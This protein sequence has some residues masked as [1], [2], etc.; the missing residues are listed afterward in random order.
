MRKVPMERISMNT[1]VK[2]AVKASGKDAQYDAEAKRLLGNKYILVYI[3]KNI[4]DEFRGM[5]PADVI[6]YIEG[7]P[8]IGTV[9]IEPGLTN[10]T[11][12]DFGQRVVGLNSE[13]SEINEGM[14]KFD[15]VFY[16][17]IPSKDGASSKNGTSSN[18]GT[19]FKNGASDK[20]PQI[21]VNAEAQKDA[22]KGYKILN[23]AVFYVSRLIS[24]Q[25]ERDFTNSNYDDLKRIFSIW[26]YMNAKENSTAHI[27]LSRDKI[28]GSHDGACRLDLI[29]IVQIGLSDELPE[30]SEPYELHR[31]LGALLSR[32]LTVDEKLNIIKNEYNI[33]IEESVR[34]DVDDM[35]NL[36][37]GIREEGMAIGR[38][39]GR[40]QAQTRVILNMHKRG[41]SIEQI[42]D[43]AE[44]SIQEAN[45]VIESGG[46]LVF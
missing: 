21:I 43:V 4:V 30:R 13:N 1:E 20:S 40:Q 19:S 33:P 17:H 44:I 32:H 38:E 26:I 34:K 3:L 2:N 11:D 31:L 46:I 14:I 27:H 24:S 41:Y 36:S 45:A 22:P 6:P 39:E 29:N 28:L 9:P 25:K 10:L 23:R 37:Q 42:A 12:K 16:A 15:I 35:C 5:P 8:Y 18:N 7:E